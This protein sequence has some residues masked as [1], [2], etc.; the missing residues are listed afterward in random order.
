MNDKITQCKADIAKLQETL[1]EL[2]QKNE[3]VLLA[4]KDECVAFYL[5]Q[6]YLEFMKEHVGEWIFIEEN[7]YSSGISFCYNDNEEYFVTEEFDV[8]ARGK[9]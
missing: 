8:L 6:E 2:E 1:E 4:I 5:K 3:T 9:V 7:E